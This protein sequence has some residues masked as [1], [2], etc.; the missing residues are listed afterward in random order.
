[1]VLV[2]LVEDNVTLNWCDVSSLKTLFVLYFE[3]NQISQ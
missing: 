1:M 3:G 2:V